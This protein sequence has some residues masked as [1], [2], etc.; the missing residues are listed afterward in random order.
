MALGVDQ[1]FA[2]VCVELAIPFTAAIPFVGQESRWTEDSQRFYYELLVAADDV[3]VV[4][5]GGY[6]SWKMQVRNEWMVDHCDLLI[7]VWD[8]TSGGTRNCVSYATKVG[9]TIRRIDPYDF[10]KGEI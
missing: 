9:R 6:A 4:S 8:G 2:Y 5:P 3:I 7:A 10:H 1:D